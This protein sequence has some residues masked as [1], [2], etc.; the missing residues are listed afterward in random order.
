[1]STIGD[2]WEEF[3]VES[4]YQSGDWRVEWAHTFKTFEEAQPYAE[5]TAKKFPNTPVRV[6]KNVITVLYQTE[7]VV[8]NCSDCQQPLSADG[9]T[10]DG[11]KN[12][13][14]LAAQAGFWCPQ[15]ADHVCKRNDCVGAECKLVTLASSARH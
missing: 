7:H 10:T 6:V 1:M 3:T 15:T 11:C 2:T 4:M 5:K 8:I 14:F 9:C 12:K 13:N